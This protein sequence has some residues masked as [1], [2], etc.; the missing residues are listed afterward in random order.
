MEIEVSTASA[1][2][3]LLT[4]FNMTVWLSDLNV[5]LMV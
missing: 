1:S 3:V 2:I 4:T 5:L